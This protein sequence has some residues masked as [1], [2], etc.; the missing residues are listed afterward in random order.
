MFPIIRNVINLVRRYPLAPLTSNY[1][2]MSNP[3]QT[4]FL[5]PTTFNVTPSCGFKVR[6]KLRRRCKDCYFVRRQERLY[7]ICETHPRH[8]Q[9]SMIKDPKNTWILTH[10]TQGKVRPW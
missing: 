3:L 2:I 5:A 9:M 1:H 10:A 4:T 8:K 7:V 6:G